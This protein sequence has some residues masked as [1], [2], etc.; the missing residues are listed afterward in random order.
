MLDFLILLIVAS[1]AI[2]GF[3]GCV[4]ITSSRDAMRDHAAQ[5]ERAQRRWKQWTS[6]PLTGHVGS[7]NEDK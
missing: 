1:V 5:Q 3:L 7:E 6:Y 4:A 2:I